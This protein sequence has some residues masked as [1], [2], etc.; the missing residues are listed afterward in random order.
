MKRKKIHQRVRDKTKEV[1]RSSPSLLFFIK[2][3]RNFPEKTFNDFWERKRE[4]GNE[5]GDYNYES[6]N[7]FVE[8]KESK[9]EKRDS[10][11]E[12]EKNGAGLPI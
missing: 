10:L 12:R 9:I 4:G 11:R 1:D 3:Q 8:S 2:I 5:R 7:L 6:M